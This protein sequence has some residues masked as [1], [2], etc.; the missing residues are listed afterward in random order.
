MLLGIAA[1]LML[2]LFWSEMCYTIGDDGV[3][4]SIKYTEHLQFLVLTFITVSL[5]I[6]AICYRKQY[7]LQ[8]R[9]CIIEMLIL[10]GFKIWLLVAF[11]QLKSVYTFTV[12][13][14]FPL[15]C[16]ILIVLAIRYSWRDATDVIARDFRRKVGRKVKK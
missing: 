2:S 10:L 14:L 6:A 7:I 15:V 8:V 12:S 13:T 4:Y 16:I 3:R 5:A 9:V 1:F 11:L